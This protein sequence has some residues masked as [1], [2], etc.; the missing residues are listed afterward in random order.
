[1]RRQL[2]PQV[3]A[4]HPLRHGSGGY[5]YDA[6]AERV[7]SATAARASGKASA[8]TVLIISFAFHPSEEIGARRTTA[9]ARFLADRGVR[10]LVVSAFGDQAVEPGSEIFPGVIAVPVARAKRRWLDLLVGLKRWMTPKATADSTSPSAPRSELGANS[11]PAGA[12]GASLASRL[13]AGYFRV[14][15]FIDELKKW[16]WDAA[17]AAVR[18]GREHGASVVLVSGPPHSTLL[19]GAWAARRLGVPFVADMRDPW[20][21]AIERW[22]PT[23]RIELRLVRA[24]E[25]WAV[26]STAAVTATSA[27][28]AELLVRRHASLASQVHVIRN[29]FDGALA[30]PRTDTGGR[31]SILYA[32]ALYVNRTP[33]P[34]LA[35]LER[36][37][38]RPGVDSSRVELTLLGDKAGSFSDQSLIRWLRGRRCAAAVRILPRQG[39]QGV[40]QELERATVLLNLAQEQHLHVPAK[41]FEQL[42]SGR[43]ILLIGEEDSETA[44]VTAGIAGV[45][46]ADPC[47]AERLDAVL[48][49]L[50]QR[51][52]VAGRARV[53]AAAEVRR[54]SRSFSN[55][56]FGALLGALAPLTTCAEVPAE[57]IRFAC[58]AAQAPAPGTR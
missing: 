25:G 50:Y 37:L 41:T 29:G 35:A 17:G 51:H 34:L 8:S 5:T 30:R 49:D 36:L 27:S 54:F 24:L 28:A 19:A 14:V 43:E 2:M 32:G 47:D 31:L 48:L 18:A 42:A 40:A 6:A 56:R 3:A 52:A 44:R 23:R 38:A 1:M 15:Y 12:A 13:R 57:A 20:S 21:D 16:S 53:P 46:R 39:P 22:H 45:T 26:R 33:Y 7:L 10:V 55:A 9:L 58:A 4:L 11:V